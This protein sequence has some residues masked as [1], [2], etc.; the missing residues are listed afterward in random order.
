MNNF[1]EYEKALAD[2]KPYLTSMFR[3]LSG[4]KCIAF[5]QCFEELNSTDHFLKPK[6]GSECLKAG[7]VKL[8]PA[9]L[10]RRGDK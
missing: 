2:G 8:I 7:G 5:G 10:K 1:T 3:C 9:F 6:L 4:P